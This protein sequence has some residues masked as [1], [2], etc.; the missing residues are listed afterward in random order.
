M[1]WKTMTY[2]CE[3]CG[4]IETVYLQEGLE[5]GPRPEHQGKNHIP[6]PFIIPCDICGERTLNSMQHIVFEWDRVLRPSRPVPAG[7]RYFRL[8]NEAERK[9]YGDRACGVPCRMP[10]R[11]AEVN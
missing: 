10:A 6:V 11:S 8:P 7:A 1:A 4:H 3:T 2:H 9:K 5:S